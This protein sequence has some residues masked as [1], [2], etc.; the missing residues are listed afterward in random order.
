MH[1]VSLTSEMI[2]F[3]VRMIAAA[4]VATAIVFPASYALSF[5]TNINRDGES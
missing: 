1:N 3:A 5:F 2:G 4:G